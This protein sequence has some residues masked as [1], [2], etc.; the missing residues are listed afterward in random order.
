MSAR[1]NLTLG[2]ADATD[3]E[4]EAALDIAQ[5]QLRPRPAVRARHPHRRA[6]AWPSPAASGSASRWPAPCSPVPRCS[7][8]TTPC[9]PSTCTPRSSSRRRWTA[10]WPHVT[11][12]VVAHRASTV[13]LADRVALLQDGT[14]THVGTHR[15]LLATVPAYKDLLAAE[16]EDDDLDL[17]AESVGAE[18]ADLERARSVT[19][20]WRGVLESDAEEAARGDPAEPARRRV[21]LVAPRAAPAAQARPAAAGPRG[22]RRERRAAVD[23]VPGQGGHRHRHPAD[24][25]RATTSS[26]CAIV[27]ALLLVATLIQA[28]AR[29]RFLVRQGEIG[30]D[31]LLTVR[32]RVFRHFQALSPA[33][34]DDY[35]SG[36]VISRQTSD[37]DAIY[38]MLETGF[39]GLVTAA[40]TLVGTAGD[41]ALPR[42]E[43]RPGGAA[44]R[45]LPRLAD[46]LVP[47]VVGGQ[48]PVDPREGR[49]GHHPLR[50]V[51]GRDPG[52]A[53]LPPGAPQPGDLRR[54]QRP[55][56]RRQPRRLPAGRLVHAGHPA[57]RQHHDRCGPAVRR[58]PRLP[59]RGHRRRA[60]GVPALPP[61]VLRA[62][63]GDLAVLQHL[64]VGLGRAGEARRGAR[65]AARRARAGG[66]DDARRRTRRAAVR[67]RQV[68]LRER[69]ARP[70]GPGP[71]RAGRAD[72]RPG[73]HD[74]GGEDHAGQARDPVLRPDRAD[75]CSSTASTCATCRRRSCARPS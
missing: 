71:H 73:R 46:Q 69:P 72:R 1:E 58:L 5:A 34:H 12:L 66:A 17:L 8:S 65:R 4:I 2:R 60:R 54:R 41:P 63:D 53:G 36:R 48:L 64:P 50:R 30:Q 55:V 33:F 43:A 40:L 56:P 9:P 18:R 31:V 75:G 39:D 32:S 61:A 14:I 21:T 67:A 70:A 20:E 6:G 3:E 23:P 27:V 15:E 57:D 11:G 35:T 49:A 68:R 26:R 28:V 51:D 13:M 47:Q 38:E 16:A 45:P 62:D 29:N 19:G 10:S 52:G 24:P 42:R 44:V 59:R 22:A 74:G 37:V 25:G 7:S